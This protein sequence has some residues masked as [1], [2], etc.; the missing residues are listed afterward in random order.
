MIKMRIYRI[1]LL[2][3]ILIINSFHVQRPSSLNGKSMSLFTEIVKSLEELIIE[4]ELEKSHLDLS[5]GNLKELF[6]LVHRALKGFQ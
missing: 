4:D 3:K 6:D 1:Y 5:L 2:K